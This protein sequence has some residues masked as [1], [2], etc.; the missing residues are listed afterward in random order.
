VGRSTERYGFFGQETGQTGD[1]GSATIEAT[2]EGANKGMTVTV[3][4][5]MS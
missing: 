1:N 5:P 2:S 3:R 4:L